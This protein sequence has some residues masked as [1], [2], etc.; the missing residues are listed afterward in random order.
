MREFSAV[1]YVTSAGELTPVR[2]QS[3]LFVFHI[4]SQL[5]TRTL[6]DMF[7]PYGNVVSTRIM[8]ERDTGR[9]RGFGFVSFD[10]PEAADA[11]IRALDGCQVQN[12]RLKVSHKKEGML[13][14]GKEMGRASRGGRGRQTAIAG[15]VPGSG[16]VSPSLL[17]APGQGGAM[18]QGGVGAALGV[19]QGIA[20]FG[21]E[22]TMASFHQQAA[23]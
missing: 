21:P 23:Q 6:Y 17:A 3:N 15:E 11:A 14:D 22:D 7:S 16:S 10:N 2:L 18:L 13:E 20:H 4:P 9:S 5:T 8:V 1:C 12:K 19:H